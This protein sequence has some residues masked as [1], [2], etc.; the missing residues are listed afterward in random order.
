MDLG[1]FFVE[2]ADELVILLDGFERLD[3]NGLPAGACAVD[4]SLDAALL[5]DFDG[6]H[7][8]LAANGD[9]LVL[10]GATFRQTAEIAA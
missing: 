1:L 3:E 10:H 4:Y 6:D 9:Q 8:A 5:L 2:Q 7:E